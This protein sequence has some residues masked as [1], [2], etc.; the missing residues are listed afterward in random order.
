MYA[1]ETSCLKRTS[2]H[3]ENNISE[4]ILNTNKRIKGSHFC[5][6]SIITELFYS[7]M[8]GSHFA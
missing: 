2:V 3:I 4:A 6:G 1:S 8:K 7:Y 5:I